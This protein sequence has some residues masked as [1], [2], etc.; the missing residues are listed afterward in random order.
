[1]TLTEARKAV[2]N[3]EHA[4]QASAR[5]LKTAGNSD[6][7]LSKSMAAAQ[8]TLM[9]AKGALANATEALQDSHLAEKSASKKYKM[10]QAGEQS[11]RKTSE[12]TLTSYLHQGRAERALS[13]ITDA[14]TAKEQ[15]AADALKDIESAEEAQRQKEGKDV[16]TLESTPV[17]ETGGTGGTGATGS[18]SATAIELKQHLLKQAI[19]AKMLAAEKDAPIT[20]ETMDGH[21]IAA[22]G[23]QA[24]DKTNVELKK[25]RLLK[26]A[27]AMK[28]ADEAI[29]GP[30]ADDD[31]SDE[32][33]AAM[34][35]AELKTAEMVEAADKET[36]MTKATLD[37]YSS[38]SHFI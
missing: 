28:E 31:K 20:V 23:A 30:R 9:V 29:A 2:T 38:T 3:A 14:E 19:K 8:Q 32:E 15:I 33:L 21:N 34:K 25:Q 13:L 4:A 6:A 26:A 18:M 12:A 36:N 22:T 37:S 5:M 24:V 11:L 17:A 10:A 27:K 16:A 1:M 35:E 7:T